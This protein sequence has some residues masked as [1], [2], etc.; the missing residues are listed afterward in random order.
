MGDDGGERIRYLGA[1]RDGSD[2]VALAPLYERVGDL[3]DLADERMRVRGEPPPIMR[4]G[5][6][7]GT[8]NASKPV[9]R[10]VL[11][12]QF[13][14]SA[15]VGPGRVVRSQ[16]AVNVLIMPRVRWSVPLPSPSPPT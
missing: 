4:H 2:A 12:L 14:R 16:V 11:A 5:A 3:I 9:A 15:C 10:T 6:S 1:D 13:D 8:G 7:G